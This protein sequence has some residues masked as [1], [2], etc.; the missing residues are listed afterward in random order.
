[1]GNHLG[2]NSLRTLERRIKVNKLFFIL[3]HVPILFRSFYNF[4]QLI[5]SF[6]SNIL[7]N[8]QLHETFIWFPETFVTS[9]HLNL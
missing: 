8:F 4:S 2:G 7:F 1:M 3:L 5:I 9:K 6:S